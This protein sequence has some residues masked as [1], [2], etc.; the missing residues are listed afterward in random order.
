[1]EQQLKKAEAAQRRKVQIEK[2]ARESEV[3]DFFF[4]YCAM[5]INELAD[6]K[7]M[8][9]V[10]FSQQEAIRKIL[11][12]D[13][14]RKKREDKNKKRLDELA[15]VLGYKHTQYTTLLLTHYFFSKT[16]CAENK[17]RVCSQEKAAQEERAS[18]CYIRTIM[19]PNGTTVSFPI[20]KVPSLFDSKPIWYA[21]LFSFS[22]SLFGIR[23]IH[24][25]MSLDLIADWI[26][27]M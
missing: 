10:L 27:L 23:P 8:I 22:Q 7:S 13:S 17:S 1:M 4:L 11:G 20:D 19:G 12:Q 15:Q 21:T 9:L 24:G 5:R 25:S 14:S 26:C 6:H 16:E 18:T 2:A 3:C